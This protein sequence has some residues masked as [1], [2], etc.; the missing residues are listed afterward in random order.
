MKIALI[1]SRPVKGNIESNIRDHVRLT[2]QAADSGAEFAVFP[3]LSI[4]GYEPTLAKDLAMQPGDP[5]LDI[6]QQ[7][8]DG[9]NITIAVGVPT[10]GATGTQISL[11][12]FQPGTDR[13]VYSKQYLHPDEF[14]FFVN[15][16]DPLYLGDETGK[17]AL[18]ICYEISV[19]E[20]SFEANAAGAAIYIASVAKTESGTRNAFT[21]LPQIAARYSMHVLM[22]NCVGLCDGVICAGSSAAWNKDGQLVGKLDGVNEGVLIFD[23]GS[24]VV[25]SATNG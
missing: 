14:P 23:T 6:F 17:I 21:T 12:V 10:S 4:T 2:R 18:A 3:E 7:L 9:E 13:Q 8:S 15:G 20:H 19:P 5:R 24:Q 22:A 25:I 11:V 16:N 1:Q